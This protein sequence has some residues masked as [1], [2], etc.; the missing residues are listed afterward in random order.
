MLTLPALYPLQPIS[1]V[2]M[3]SAAVSVSRH[4]PGFPLN[5]LLLQEQSTMAM[6]T[7]VD[8]ELGP[9]QQTERVLNQGIICHIPREFPSSL[10]I[11]QQ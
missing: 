8:G 9:I 2:I 10:C 5:N 3:A 11:V 6:V 4:G 7:G 1:G